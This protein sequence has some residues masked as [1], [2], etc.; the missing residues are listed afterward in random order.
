MDLLWLGF[1]VIGALSLL[2][3]FSHERQRRIDV[4]TLAAP[5]APQATS[6]E[7]V[8]PAYPMPDEAPARKAA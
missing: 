8:E 4:R 6:P 1:A 3:L 5:V 7:T 2:A